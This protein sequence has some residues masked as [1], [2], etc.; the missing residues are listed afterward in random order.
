MVQYSCVWLAWSS[1][2]VFG[3]HYW[4]SIVM[5]GWHGPVNKQVGGSFTGR[6]TPQAGQCPIRVP[7]AN[8]TRE[9]QIYYQYKKVMKSLKQ[10]NTS[11][12]E[13]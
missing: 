3:W 12:T 5:C 7:L 13:N 8:N 11:E 1:I 2:V 9:T 10:K 4:Y 6:C